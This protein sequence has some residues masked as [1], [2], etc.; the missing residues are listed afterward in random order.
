MK[1]CFVCG[2][3]RDGARSCRKHIAKQ[4]SRKHVSTTMGDG[5]F[6]GVREKEL[7]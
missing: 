5:V 6:R 4:R 2:P 7:S 1:L 3:R